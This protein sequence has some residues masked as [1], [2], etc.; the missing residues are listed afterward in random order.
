MDYVY[1]LKS[2]WCKVFLKADSKALKEIPQFI[3][4]E[5]G[6]PIISGFFVEFDIIDKTHETYY[7]KLQT[8]YFVD[9]T[10]ISNYNKAN[11]NDKQKY[12]HK[13]DVTEIISIEMIFDKIGYNM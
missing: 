11:A 10:E 5:R 2:L 9:I 6:K 4:K 8:F 3:I 13:I 7:G 12:M 1:Y